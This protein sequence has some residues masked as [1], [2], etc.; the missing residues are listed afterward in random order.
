VVLTWSYFLGGSVTTDKSLIDF[1]IE[2]LPTVNPPIPEP[3]FPITPLTVVKYTIIS[4]GSS[5]DQTVNIEFSAPVNLEA[6]NQ[7]I[8]VKREDGT[9]VTFQTELDRIGTTLSVN[10]TTNRAGSYTITVQSGAQDVLGGVLSSD[11]SIVY[12]NA[13]P[14]F[15]DAMPI[16]VSVPVRNQFVMLNANHQWVVY[17]PALWDKKSL[18]LFVLGNN[19]EATETVGYISGMIPIDLTDP[20]FT[21]MVLGSMLSLGADSRLV[22]FSGTG[23][24]VGYVLS[25]GIYLLENTSVVVRS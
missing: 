4:S 13:M 5:Y 25:N 11:Y 16:T 19:P 12:T 6:I 17:D 22:T 3:V 20:D 8:T 7:K 14:F 10:F 1:D 18:L 15:Y 21:F 2:S 23:S 9:A 24:V